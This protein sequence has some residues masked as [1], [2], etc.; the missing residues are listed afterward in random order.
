MHRPCFSTRIDNL[1]EL[2]DKK[3]ENLSDKGNISPGDTADAQGRHINC[4]N[5]E[6]INEKT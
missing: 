4:L 2:V 6:N 3:L 5:E 1:S